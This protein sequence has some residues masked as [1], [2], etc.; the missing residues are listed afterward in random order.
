M[1]NSSFSCRW[2]DFPSFNSPPPLLLR[3]KTTHGTDRTRYAGDSSCASCHRQL[4]QNYEHTPHHLTSQLPTQSSVLGSFHDGAN[5]LTIIDAAQVRSTGTSVSH[6]VKEGRLLR[7]CDRPAGAP[8]SFGEPN[9]SIL[10]QD[11]EYAVR[12]ICIGRAIGFLNY[13]SVI[14]AMD[15]DGSTVPATLTVP[16]I[17]PAR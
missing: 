11:P 3:K 15:I 17:F 5:S 12:L 6:G 2:P 4:S 8:T 9:A 13:R 7:D 16:R 10:S 1:P 14:G